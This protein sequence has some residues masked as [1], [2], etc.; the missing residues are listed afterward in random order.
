MGRKIIRAWNDLGYGLI[1][2]FL[3]GFFLVGA[4]SLAYSGTKEL[5]HSAW[6]PGI[7]PTAYLERH[8]FYP[9][10]ASAPVI[11]YSAESWKQALLPAIRKARTSICVVMYLANKNEFNEEVYN[12]LIEKAAEG[13]KV[14]FLFDPSS[15]QRI[16]HNAKWNPEIIP[17]SI[18]FRGTK[19]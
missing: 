18:V 3:A 16:L 12:A 17:P 19:V 2:V 4:A 5:S 15:Y 13:V 11:H 14:L 6:V 10:D 7:A 1:G 9:V 8:G